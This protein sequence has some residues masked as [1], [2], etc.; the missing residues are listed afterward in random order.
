[1]SIYLDQVLRHEEF[2]EGCAATCNGPYNGKWSKTMVGYGPEAN[3]FV[4]E[5]TY[6]YEVRSIQDW[7]VHISD[8][9]SK[10][11]EDTALSRSQNRLDLF[12]LIGFP[13]P[14][15]DK[16]ELGN[17]FRGIT[18]KSTKAF[19]SAVDGKN[20]VVVKEADEK[21]KV[22]EA[23]D[24]YNFIIEN[25]DVAKGDPVQR[26]NVGVSRDGRV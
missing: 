6:N 24:G 7:G 13:F 14:Q 1:M 15:V 18:I 8:T 3:H 23:P 4:V 10:D 22:V 12:R 19:A 26:V 2:E 25:E 16:Y 17:D 20:N 9:V 21:R 11:T 5:L